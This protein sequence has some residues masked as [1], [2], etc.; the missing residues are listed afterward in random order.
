MKRFISF[1]LLLLYITVATAGNASFKKI[2]VEQNVKEFGVLGLKVLVDFNLS[3]LNGELI[4][5]IAVFEQ[6]KGVSVKA[7]NDFTTTDGSLV[8]STGFLANFKTFSNFSLF[9]PN[10]KLPFESGERYY[11]RVFIQTLK[12]EILGTSEYASFI[13]SGQNN[14]NTSQISRV[15]SNNTNSKGKLNTKSNS[16]NG[17][18]YVDLG[19]PSGTKWATMN[20]GA[21][22]TKKI[23]NL[24]AWGETK[25]F[26]DGKRNFSWKT[27][28]YCKSSAE[29][30]TKYHYG[31][32]DKK[33]ELDISD[34]AA[35]IEWGSSW[36]IPTKEQ[37]EELFDTKNC[38]YEYKSST[39]NN[40]IS[41]YLIKSKRN[42]KSIFFPAG[43]C[44]IDEKFNSMDVQGYYWTRSLQW[45]DESPEDIA[46]TFSA[47]FSG[48][49]DSQTNIT[50]F[51]FWFSPWVNDVAGQSRYKGMCIRPVTK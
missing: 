40:D 10:S 22:D 26:N 9:I 5:A 2:R 29:T 47:L 13:F 48:K 49:Y 21:K 46:D 17:H 38:T 16:I 8:T 20:I 7:K 14:T 4:S 37:F 34:D 35:Y 27:Y 25:G 18:E 1:L 24:Y 39:D 31:K 41:G 32:I 23:G 30:L 44:I 6:P 12:G 3:G 15:K 50:A 42:G 36:R 51:S 11:T 45:Q 33:K 43:G 28:K 19:L